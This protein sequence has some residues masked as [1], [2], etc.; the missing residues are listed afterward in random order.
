[1]DLYAEGE[2]TIS[3]LLIETFLESGGTTVGVPPWDR[4][5]WKIWEPGL[6]EGEN[7]DLVAIGPK[8]VEGCYCLPNAALKRVT[9]HLVKPYRN[10]IVDSPAGLEHL[11]R[12]TVKGFDVLLCVVD[13]GAQSIETAERINRLAKYI[14]VK[15]VLAVGSKVTSSSDERFIEKSASEIGL[16]VIGMVPFDPEVLK[17]D[18]M[19]VAPIDLAPSSPAIS[20]IKN[21]RDTLK[22][23]LGWS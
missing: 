5:E 6:Y 18:R 9:E 3:E 22:A 21:L 8:W 13:P 20:A 16:E 19:R 11:G 23:R 10:V 7:F 17:A 4:I 2:K 1:M 15:E 12:A 14:N